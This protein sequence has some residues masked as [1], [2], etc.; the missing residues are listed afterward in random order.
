M[1]LP[2]FSYTA[3]LFSVFFLAVVSP[4]LSGKELG[5]LKGNHP[6]GAAAHVPGRHSHEVPRLSCGQGAFPTPVRRAAGVP[7]PKVTL[8]A[9]KTYDAD[10][11]SS[12]L[13][14]VY[15]IEAKENG[16]VKLVKTLN[17]AAN[18]V[19]AVKYGSSMHCISTENNG[20][21]AYF[22]TLNTDKWNMTGTKSEISVDDVPS[23]LT[24]DPN[25]GKVY[26]AVYYE[27][28]QTYDYG[29]IGF[30]EFSL[31]THT[32]NIRKVLERDV[33]A[34]AADNSG[35]VHLMFGTRTGWI[36]PATLKW[37]TG[38]SGVH[39]TYYP[40]GYNTM[41]WDETSGLLYAIVSE[42]QM[43]AGQ[44]SRHTYLVK[45]DPVS[46]GYTTLFEFPSHQTYAGL[47][48]MPASV[49]KEAP[50]GV[51]GVSVNFP[52][53]R[54][55]EG[56]V[57]FTAP[58]E[59]VA[60][61]ELTADISVIIQVGDTEYAI[62]DVAP[63]AT[64]TS[65]AYTFPYGKQTVKITTANSADRGETV[66]TDIFAGEDV[67]CAVTG[68]TLDIDGDHPQIS[69]EAP[70]AGLN[71]G[72]VDPSSLIY[73]VVRQP[74][75]V[76][77]TTDL[78]DTRFEDSAYV[79]ALEAISYTVTPR[80][81]AG[82]GESASTAKAVLG[83]E[84][85]VP[86]SEDFGS[87]DNF[88][89]WT[90]VNAN[91]GSTWQ[92]SPND[93]TAQYEY[94][95]TGRLPG[96]DWLIS[97]PI[98]FEAGKSYTLSYEY[99]G[100]YNG[101][102]ESFEVMLGASVRPADMTTCLAS[103]KDIGTGKK[104]NSLLF[105]VPSDG[106]YRLGF[107]ATSPAYQYILEIDNIAIDLLQGGAPAAAA[108]MSVTPAAR[109]ALSATVSLVL[110][111][112]DIDGNPLSSGLSVSV[113]RTGASAPVYTATGLVHGATV[114]FDDAVQQ[115]GVYDYVAT[116]SNLAGT[117]PETAA[118][119]YIG[120][121]VPDAVQNLS[122][123]GNAD[124]KPVLTWT[125]PTTGRNGGWFDDSK[126]TYN[127]YRY[128]GDLDLIAER[129]ST[130][131]AT[132]SGLDVSGGQQFV[133]YVVTPYSGDDAG[134][135][136]ES[137][138]MLAGAPYTAPLTEGFAK[139]G[140]TWYPWVS[141]TDQPLRQAWTL[142]A[143]GQQHGC[144][145]YDGN[146]GLATFHSAGESEKGVGSWFES[147]KIDIRQLSSPQLRFALYLSG[148]PAG[149]ESI[150]P[151]LSMAGAGYSPLCQPV[152]RT[153]GSGWKLFSVAIP[154][155][156]LSAPWIR[157]AFKGVTDG[158]A[159]MYLDAVSIADRPESPVCIEKI[160]GASK[161]AVD[162]PASFDIYIANTDSEPSQAAVL[163]L[164][165]EG[166]SEVS[167]AVESLAPGERKIIGTNY[168]FTS[169]GAHTLTAKFGNA[170]ATHTVMCVD[171]LL[172]RV[173]DLA[174]TRDEGAVLLSWN[175][176][177]PRG[178]VTD[179]FE[180]YESWAIDGIGDWTMH[181]QDLDQTYYINAK[182]LLP[183]APS[184][185]PYSTTP[186]A[187]QVCDADELCINEW[188]EGSP[189]TGDKM[190]MAMANVNYVNDDW[191]VSPRLNGEAQ[192]ISLYAKAFTSSGIAPERLQV[193]C[194]TTGDELSSFT[195]LHSA[196]YLS[197]TDEW[198]PLE[199]DLPEGAKYFA[200]RCVS[201]GAFALFVDDVSF[202]DTTVP[203]LRLSHY[204]VLR[205]GEL[206]TTVTGP[207][208]RDETAPVTA[209]TYAVR[210]VYDKGSSDSETVTATDNSSVQGP[211]TD[212]D[213]QKDTEIYTTTGICL[214]KHGRTGNLPRG[215]YL[216]R[217]GKI[218]K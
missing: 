175:A 163:T 195:A 85:S 38:L 6:A 91:G 127:V 101:M 137:P 17:L 71:G 209:C 83:G 179:S 159:D 24:V 215:L 135:A 74:G 109:G 61:N 129:V 49:D 211:V 50:K 76:V 23:D 21:N 162:N 218:L 185:Y 113:T 200:L 167:F 150:Q 3:L 60:G 174:A 89:L 177:S 72:P 152:A 26:G 197:I 14:G 181:D 156:A 42:E 111:D 87:Q 102:K 121:D 82:D 188:P 59:T 56:T 32:F 184:D 73:K 68:L 31:S 44:K 207:E 141:V 2:N 198:T 64:V 155:E 51:T 140:M 176:P 208:Y 115:S 148:T 58:T 178:A 103:H 210:A 70:V 160:A 46:F 154:A 172:P 108:D 33:Y 37:D 205:D 110:P 88:D 16:E 153:S 190:L 8:C 136:I 116:V 125:A 117:G 41:T 52:S 126:L 144:S 63:G 100:L 69:W 97:P 19:A 194:S 86:H 75:N 39:N 7:E 145:D 192:R 131:T 62:P 79:P 55:T 5:R 187:W 123:A 28:T 206:L 90:V 53:L 92:Y 202:Y 22:F 128:F 147:P 143:K 171:P 84:W 47:H 120:I 130:L 149:N 105:T 189:H 40:E 151:M 20:G 157:I 80:S 204:E 35:R 106:K 29:F 142:D 146:G 36:E 96:D 132:D 27:D 134:R 11:S 168:T 212:A 12:E 104:R 98:M 139:A 183:Q 196:G 67:P 112:N 34:L 4:P 138:Y 217:K 93:K 9:L 66:M 119:A 161:V 216:T 164:A 122:I 203:A 169:K 133:S 182:E 13:A 45:I 118:S 1:R 213:N 54:S 191:A 166:G 199:F 107:H 81:S 158:A 25:T 18:V 214:G 94:D 114:S 30:G 77:L 65:P 57:S 165:G 170:S 180:Q 201:D 15:T 193:L 43:K 10:W 124:G 78:R 173:T 95:D 48:V 99:R 186:K